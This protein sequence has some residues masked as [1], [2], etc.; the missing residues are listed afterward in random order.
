MKIVLRVTDGPRAGREF[1][2]ENHEAFVVGRSPLVSF[3]IPEDDALSRYHFLIEFHPPACLLRDLESRNGTFVND[4]PARG[5]VRLREGDVVAAGGSRFAIQLVESSDAASRE[6]RIVCARCGVEAPPDLIRAG[7]ETGV[8][9]FQWHCAP[10]GRERGNLPDPPPGYRILERVG[11][12]GMGVVYKARHLKTDRLV[13]IKLMIPAVAASERAKQ[14]FRREINVIRDLR[15]PNILRYYGVHESEG[16]FQLITEF[17]EGSNLNQWRK[18]RKGPVPIPQALTVGIQLLEALAHAHDKGY[19][20][21]DIK[22]SNI[23]LAG[24]DPLVPIVK[25]TDFGLSKSFRD[26]AGFTG[27]THQ[28]DVGGSLGFLAPD[29]IRNFREAREPADIY[30]TGATLYHLLT[31]RYPLLNFDPSRG[32]AYAMIL[33]HPPVPLRVHRPDAPDA[34]VEILARS[35]QKRPEQRWRS[36][37]EMADALKSVFYA[38]TD[39]S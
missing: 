39:A 26:N 17:V 3:P 34:L 22:P 25:L 12:G 29:Q 1:V 8:T 38:R 5:S 10:C 36:A 16:Q 23:L 7:D 18:A 13:A 32:D 31:G 35:L 27:L 11:E 28:D 20:H 19:V 15:H 14:Y 24:K 9:S 6:G 4:K 2:A 33:E 21:R 37:Q 30:S